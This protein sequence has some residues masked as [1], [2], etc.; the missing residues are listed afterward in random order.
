MRA[1]KV[2]QVTSIAL[3]QSPPFQIIRIDNRRWFWGEETALLEQALY[4]FADQV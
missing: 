2:D 4:V 3:D 1:K